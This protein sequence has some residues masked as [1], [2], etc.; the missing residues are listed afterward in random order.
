MLRRVGHGDAT[1]AGKGCHTHFTGGQRANYPHSQRVRERCE[2]CCFSFD[3]IFAER[4]RLDRGDPQL[5]VPRL[6]LGGN[7]ND[8]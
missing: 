6:K 5:T 8:G 4:C 3:L 7:A 2:D 1:A